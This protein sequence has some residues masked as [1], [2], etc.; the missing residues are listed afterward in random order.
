VTAVD[1]SPEM[2]AQVEGAETVCSRIENLDLERALDA[3]LLASNLITAKPDQPS[4]LPRGLQAPCRRSGGRGL[5]TGLAVIYADSA[6]GL[7]RDDLVEKTGAVHEA[8]T[9]R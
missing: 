9:S 3:A 2:L 8:L 5:A 6:R 7:G 1:E 4:R